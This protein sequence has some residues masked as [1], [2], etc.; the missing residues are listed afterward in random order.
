MDVKKLEN[1]S[2]LKRIDPTLQVFLIQASSFSYSRDDGSSIDN[3]AAPVPEFPGQ[4][5]PP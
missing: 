5:L 2:V 1:P 4:A 3:S